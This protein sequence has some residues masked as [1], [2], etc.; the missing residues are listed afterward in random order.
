[1]GFKLRLLG[2]DGSAAFVANGATSTVTEL[3]RNNLAANATQTTPALGEPSGAAET[4][5]VESGPFA[6]SLL[7]SGTNANLVAV[8]LHRSTAT[9]AD[10]AFDVQLVGIGLL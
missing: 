3:A 2:A 1:A 4:A 10:L 6:K 8:E 5:F 7:T 9:P